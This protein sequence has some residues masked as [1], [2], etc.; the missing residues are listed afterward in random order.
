MCK[1]GKKCVEVC[2]CAR[3]GEIQSSKSVF[4]KVCYEK[5]SQY[6]KNVRKKER[7][8][9]DYSEDLFMAV[10]AASCFIPPLHLSLFLLYLSPLHKHTHKHQHSHTYNIQSQ[11]THNHT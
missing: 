11:G 6:G 9:G 8:E 1:R 5:E 4:E 2:V 10:T 7:R 3:V